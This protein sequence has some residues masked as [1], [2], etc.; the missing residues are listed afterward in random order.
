[1]DANLHQ[2]KQPTLAILTYADKTRI[3]RG[4][5]KN[6]VD[7]IRTGEEHDV[8]VYVMTTTDF[9]VNGNHAV[10]YTYNPSSK[11]WDKKLFPLPNI[12]YNRIPY[13]KF[14]LQPE[15]QQI[16]QSCMRNS[17]IQFFNPSFFNKWTLFEWLNQSKQTQPFIPATEQMTNA[18]ALGDLL[19]S[20]SSLYLKPI[21]GKAGKGIMKVSLTEKSKMRLYELSIQDKT[22]SHISRYADI[23]KLWAQIRDLTGSKEY[24]VQQGI[25][26]ASYK[27]RPFDLRVL[28]Q[29]NGNG[30]WSIA[31][32]GARLA[33][34]MSITTHVPRGGSIDDPLKLLSASFGTQGSKRIISKAKQAALT[35]ARQIE[36][37]SGHTLGE[38]SMDLGVDNNKNIW[39]FEANSKPMKFD[40]P[41][42]RK[43]SLE[44]LIRY[45]L[46]L[47][48]MKQKSIA[49][50]SAIVKKAVRH[51]KKPARV[52]R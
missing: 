33:G 44:N 27:D 45:S 31:G 24:I 41:Q 36:K 43:K 17:Q 20:H 49:R 22:K 14:E 23:H 52:G 9:K 4:N 51:S 25:S 38:M 28:V 8:R 29:K 26:L 11:R 16:I 37:A 35:I 1:M 32:V 19:K 48:D 30:E 3:F 50:K 40:E 18:N 34:K 5:Q 42:I 15:V 7:L 6:F 12:I 2:K 47:S 39:F 21:R 10:G 13:R 46:F